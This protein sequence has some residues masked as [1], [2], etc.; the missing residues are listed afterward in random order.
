M[1]ISAIV[2]S[3][4]KAQIFVVLLTVTL[5]MVILGGVLTIQG[6]QA[7]L[8]SES[9]SSDINQ[10]NALIDQLTSDFD[11]ANNV[12][13]S[14]SDNNVINSSLNSDNMNSIEVYSVLYEI[15]S[16][17]RDF[18]SIDIYQGNNCIYS[19]NSNDVS[20]V[21]PLNYS[22]LGE[23][24]RNPGN[25]VYGLDPEDKSK[26]PDLLI[27]I[28]INPD[29]GNPSFAV[30]R[31]NPTVMAYRLREKINAKDGFL[32]TDRFFR[33]YCAIG[34]A[35][36]GFELTRIK[37]NL[38]EHAAYDQGSDNNIYMSDIGNTGLI[39]IYI[40]PQVIGKSVVKVGYQ[41]IVILSFI[42]IIVCFLVARKLS[43]YFSKP[44]DILTAGMK[45]FRKGDFETMISLNRTD[46]FEQLATGFN[47][48]TSQ[49]KDTMEKKLEAERT[50][51]ETRIKMMQAQLNPHFLYNTLDTIKWVTKVNHIPEV[52]TMVASL[53]NILRASISENEF[54][55]LSKEL[56]LVDNYCQIQQIRFDNKFDI[57]IDVPAD[58]KNAIVPKL[59]LQPIVE[60]AII[61]GLDEADNGMIVINAERT[62][63]AYF[64]SSLQDNLPVPAD[65]KD[66]LIISIQDNG[67]GID[68]AAIAS[69]NDIENKP[70]KGHLGLKNVITILRL[71]YGSEYG[72]YP[73]RLEEGGTIM[74]ITL[75]YQEEEPTK[76]E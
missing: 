8:K 16:S 46:E 55:A 7:R 76:V 64:K 13:H 42:S 70:P 54:C 61:H 33:P 2:K 14:I 41:I 24:L 37:K 71:Y 18:T 48:M 30:I 63:L 32:L 21:L 19:T 10:N 53:A 44:I 12:L 26:N 50:I 23:A 20:K 36:N 45:R 29:A 4:F 73:K 9:R 3:S 57:K 31:I 1:K 56:E 34:T 17:L 35:T 60:N 11:L 59:I 74:Y 72:V 5:V 67:K 69:L 27:A 38:F 47:K 22:V 58:L 43:N 66:V 28:S 49:L 40:T 6:F 68:A 15:T 52:S 75:P 65:E 51:N 39:S 62:S 25:V